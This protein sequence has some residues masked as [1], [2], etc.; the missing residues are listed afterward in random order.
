[1]NDFDFTHFCFGFAYIKYFSSTTGNGV[2]G[3]RQ[4]VNNKV[5]QRTKKKVTT[6]LNGTTRL[7]DCC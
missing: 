7:V 1:M 5:R 6:I 3:R 2:Y 4:R